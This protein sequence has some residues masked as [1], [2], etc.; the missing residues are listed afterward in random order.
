MDIN[1]QANDKAEDQAPGPATGPTGEFWVYVIGLGL[2]VILTLASFA[3]AGTDLVWGPGIPVLLLVL[4]LAQM[5]VHL[6]F[7]LRISS[8]PDHANNILALA[9][10][11][12][13]VS[14]VLIGSLWIMSNLNANMMPMEQG[15]IPAMI[16]D[17]PATS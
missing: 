4:A 12:L 11:V 5:G 10:G 7:F 6:V 15:G 8:G 17:A 9:F 14:L 1:A 3:V 2:A 13:I 16:G